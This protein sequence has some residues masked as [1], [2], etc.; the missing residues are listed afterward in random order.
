MYMSPEQAQGV[1]E[2]DYRCDLYSLAIVVFEMLAGEPPFDAEEPLAI[3]RKHVEVA[4]PSLRSL[5]PK[6]PAH[7]DAAVARALAKTPSDR[8]A[9]CQV[10]VQALG[11]SDRAAFG[12]VPHPGHRGTPRKAGFSA[13]VLVTLTLLV[14]AVLCTLVAVIVSASRPSAKN[15]SRRV[16][17]AEA[18]SGLATERSFSDAMRYCLAQVRQHGRNGNQQFVI[19]EL[20]SSAVRVIIHRGEPEMIDSVQYNLLRRLGRVPGAV[21]MVYRCFPEPP[22]V[23]GAWDDSLLVHLG[24]HA[25]VRQVMVYVG[26]QPVD[27]RTVLSQQP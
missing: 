27:I 15:R 14:L 13:G 23:A 17:S 5:V 9:S 12:A 1:G 19:R 26:G 3:L 21:R 22:T 11:G 16:A 20:G 24:S 6:V 18:G 10:F 8:F 4:P 2:V 25:E 7:T